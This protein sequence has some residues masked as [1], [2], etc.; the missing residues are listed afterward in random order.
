MKFLTIAPI[1]CQ[2]FPYFPKESQMLRMTTSDAQVWLAQTDPIP[3]LALDD[4]VVEALGY[5]TQSEYAETY[6]LP[7]IGPTALWALRRL[8]RWLDE[9]PEGFP[10]ALVPF[11]RE[12]G[13]GDGAG[14]SSPV[15]R[16]LA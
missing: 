3:V 9:T 15:V 5:D 6:W 10:L 1:G 11:S 12:L 16:T 2:V 13:L 8:T 14:R 4:Q 7:V